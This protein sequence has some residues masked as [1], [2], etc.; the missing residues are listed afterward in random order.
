MLWCVISLLLGLDLVVLLGLTL[1][2][3]CGMYFGVCGF[4][5]LWGFGGCALGGCF[6]IL[7]GWLVCCGGCFGAAFWLFW[8][9]FGYDRGS[10]IFAFW[11]CGQCTVAVV[12]FAG[13]VFVCCG[14][15]F[16]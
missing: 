1:V 3:W 12:S 14:V 4:L 10:W 15:H 9:G 13:L 7:C 5:S 6:W 16:G 11:V 8:L 2:G